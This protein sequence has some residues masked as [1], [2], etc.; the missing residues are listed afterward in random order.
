MLIVSIKLQDIFMF[1]T[2]QR[3]LTTAILCIF[4]GAI[5]Q[6]YHL[7]RREDEKSNKEWHRKEGVQS[8]KWCPSHKFHNFLYVFYSVTQSLFLLGSRKTSIILQEAKKEHV[9][10]KAY[11]CIWKN[12]IIFAQKY[13][14]FTT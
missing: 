7:R 13:Y 11:Q 4:I 1:L 8:K 10:G 6:V 5:K 9:Q 14:K 3:I 2:S 12:Y